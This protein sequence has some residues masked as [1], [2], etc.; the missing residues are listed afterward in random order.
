MTKALELIKELIQDQSPEE[1]ADL[2]TPILEEIDNFPTTN[3]ADLVELF[4]ENN[5][6]TIDDTGKTDEIN[7][8]Q[9]HC[10]PTPWN[11]LYFILD[12]TFLWTFLC[13]VPFPVIVP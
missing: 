7:F 13:T 12:D 4:P 2:N 6:L 11:L 1:N 9:K 10:S 5:W 8:D 3:D